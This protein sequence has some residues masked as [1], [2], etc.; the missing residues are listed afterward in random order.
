MLYYLKNDN[1]THLTKVKRTNLANLGWKEKDLENLIAN[2]ISKILSEE[3]LMTIF[4]ERQFQEEP[5]IMA[6]DRYG[7]LYIIELKRWQSDKSNLLQVMRYGQKYGQYNYDDLNVLY[8]KYTK[9]EKELI[10]IHKEYFNL[11]DEDEK[12][13]KEDFNKSQH[14][15]IITDGIDIDTKQAIDYWKGVGLS[16]DSIIYRVYKLD[17]ENLIE[18][19]VYSP[20]DD[21]IELEEGCYILNTN[22]KGC[23]EDD[24]YMIKNKR[25][26][27]FY[28]PWKYKIEKF[29]KG[30][31]VFL[32][33]SGEGIVAMGKASG[34][35]NHKN[36]HDLESEV[37]E[38]YYTDLS[39]FE[40]LKN[41]LCASEIKKVT[42]VNH[43]FKSVMFC[44]GE[45]KGNILWNYIKEN[46]L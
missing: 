34:I 35:V 7:K 42:G 15:L 44:I 9:E 6:L 43:V 36:Y 10:D 23:P 22:K 21:V 33:R 12:I 40:E 25:A 31:K 26:A 30:D 39:E 38:E 29:N 20:D 37:D 4:Q 27:A 1:K 2:N 11:S 17:N 46:C 5:D 19:N 45:E 32:Y 8:K 41:P 18:F 28:K 16:I 14:F 13:K 3:S 24:P